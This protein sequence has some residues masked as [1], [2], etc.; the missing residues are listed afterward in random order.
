[1]Y[2]SISESATA[3]FKPFAVPTTLFAQQMAYLKQQAY[4]PMTVTEFVNTRIQKDVYALPER[5]VILTFDDGF[6]D[7]FTEA[8][9]ILQQYGFPATLYAATAYINGTSRWMQN[10]GEGERPM[11]TWE[12]LFEISK[13]G[14]ECGGH[15]HCHRQLDTLPR[16]VVR[17]EIA[18]CKRL[19]ESHL[20][21]EVL[22]FA[23]PH[24]Y[25]T[26]AIKQLIREAGFTSACAVK[27][28]MSSET[29]DPFALPRL[30]V[31]A[32]TSVAD[33]AALLVQP[34]PSV[35]QCCTNVP[36]VLCGGLFGATQRQYM[37]PTKFVNSINS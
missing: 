18:Q 8:F 29:S 5:P 20:H 37:V 30:L 13:H 34:I 14:I 33:L 35:E 21:Q 10:E 4:T 36:K 16:S 28:M 32:D 19:L 31:S 15:S 1:M 2:H 22:S 23:Y 7:F 6:A 25:H 12:Q 17:E 3:K 26:V 11:L 27:Y 24:G 9:P